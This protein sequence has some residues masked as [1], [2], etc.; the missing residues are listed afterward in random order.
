MKTLKIF[1]QTHCPFCIKAFKYIEELKGEH[2]EYNS[3]SIEMIEE[4]E[5]PEIADKYDYYY[6][7]SFYIGEDKV[8][9]AGIFKP[10]VDA[11]LR[12]VLDS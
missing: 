2:P 12:M 6:V 9:E 7:P 11:I 10:E 8:H 4:T 1:Y 3:I 5:H